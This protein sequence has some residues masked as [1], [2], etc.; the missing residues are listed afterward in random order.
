MPSERLSDGIAFSLC[1]AGMT[2]D[3]FMYCQWRASAHRFHK[4]Y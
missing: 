4:I 1:C 2:I 3:T